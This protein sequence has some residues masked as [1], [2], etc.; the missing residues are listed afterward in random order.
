[1]HRFLMMILSILLATASLAQV[2]LPN[3]ISKQHKME[4][5]KE[6]ADANKL[7]AALGPVIAQFVPVGTCR[8]PDPQRDVLRY[9]VNPA[10]D[11]SRVREIKINYENRGAPSGMIFKSPPTPTSGLQTT[12]TVKDSRSTSD[13]LQTTGFVLQA[14]DSKGRTSSRRIDYHYLDPTPRLE[15]LGVANAPVEIHRPDGVFFEYAFRISVSNM[16]IATIDGP[17]HVSLW[18]DG[19]LTTAPA[20]GAQL[21][22]EYSPRGRKRAL[23]RP[24]RRF[25][26]S[27]HLVFTYLTPVQSYTV[28]RNRGYDRW[29]VAIRLGIHQPRGCSGQPSFAYMEIPG[30]SAPPPRSEP[31]SGPDRSSEPFYNAY[32]SEVAC[33]C[34]DEY[35]EARVTVEGCMLDQ[36]SAPRMCSAAAATFPSKRTSCTWVTGAYRRISREMDCN[37]INPAPKVTDVDDGTD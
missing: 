35:T 14:T 12:R 16:S 34:S 8:Y 4:V 1:M 17:D 32:R 36:R 18:K 28:Y 7:Q 25:E 13:Y 9:R 21:W 31:D 5:L 24:T 22:E 15:Y 27:E 10:P 33:N 37:D 11:G 30:R 6:T 2:V 26:S 20:M 3:T 23:R 19:R 29:S